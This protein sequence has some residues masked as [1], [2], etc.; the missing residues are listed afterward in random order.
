M[1]LPVCMCV[2]VCVCVCVFLSFYG[3]H[4]HTHTHTRTHT[5][6]HARAH[7]QYTHTQAY[8]DLYI[9]QVMLDMTHEYHPFLIRR[10]QALR[11]IT[12]QPTGY[13]WVR[14]RLM[15][16]CPGVELP[17]VGSIRSRVH[18]R[19]R[20]ASDWR[21]SGVHGKREREIEAARAQ[22]EVNTTGRTQPVGDQECPMD[23]DW[24]ENERRLLLWLRVHD[25][26]AE[27]ETEGPKISLVRFVA[28][29]HMYLYAHTRT[30][31]HARTH[32]LASLIALP[33]LF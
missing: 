30:D 33:P 17:Q 10:K 15:A 24:T 18:N 32:S 21:K 28:S 4:T 9:L 3:V 22:R 13:D 23:T 25:L 29:G 31:A 11:D 8:K 1:R 6:T 14:E 7:T 5:H 12:S 2:C 27:T 20:A 16:R 19:M 26:S